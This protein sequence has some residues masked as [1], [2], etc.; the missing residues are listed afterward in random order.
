MPQRS[1]VICLLATASIFAQRA[2]VPGDTESFLD[3]GIDA[4]RT[5]DFQKAIQAFQVAIDFDANDMR[6][7]LYLAS[8][9]MVLYVPGLASEE[10]RAHAETARTEFK[11]VLELNPGNPN[12]LMSLGTLSLREAGDTDHPDL[13]KLDD[14]HS[15]F[16]KVLDGEPDNKNALY[17]IA[18]I[19]WR[20]VNPS[21][22]PG[23]PGPLPDVTQR[24]SLQAQYR[25]IVEEGIASLK[26]TLET[27]PA[28]DSAMSYL[29]LLLRD[30]AELAESPAESQ[31]DIQEADQWVQKMA[32]MRTVRSQAGAMR[33]AKRS[34]GI[35]PAQPLTKVDPAYPALARQAK[36][37]GTVR[38]RATIG[39]D[40]SVVNLELISGHPLLV[41]AAKAAA[42]Q[43]TFKPTLVNGQPVQVVTTVDVN[44]SLDK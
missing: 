9:N 42:K 4:Y 24:H 22:P 13:A 17:T 7:H 8:A 1:I 3:N 6:A 36:I 34:A 44:F 33:P 18:V 26:K 14:A 30:R 43:W 20:K 35:A 25:P 12:A 40:G 41:A 38:F 15:W 5:G 39:K 11:R 37:Q 21:L 31:K 32:D 16:Q 10:N 23:Q 28:F 2:H 29:N 19:D 27:D